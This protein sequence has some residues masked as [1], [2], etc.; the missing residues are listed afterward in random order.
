VHQVAIHLLCAA[1]DARIAT[2]VGAG[3]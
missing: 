1:I 3:R 2:P